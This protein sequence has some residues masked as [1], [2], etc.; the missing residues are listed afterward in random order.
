VHRVYVDN[1][2]SAT[3]SNPRPA[4]EE[5]MRDVEDGH[6]QIVV[7]WVL[8]RVLRTGRDRLRMLEL[9]KQRGITIS[10]VRGSDMDLSTP[11][12]R[13]AADMLGAVALHE[14]EAKSDRQKAAHRQAAAQGRRIG[15]RRPFGFEQDGMTVRPAEAKALEAAY[16]DYL[17]GTPLLAIARQ[18]NEAGLVS[19]WKRPDGTFSEWNHSGVRSV[20]RNARYAGFRVHNGEIA[21]KALWPA[22]VDEATYRAVVALLDSAASEFKP[23]GGR[24][25]LTG[26]ARCGVCDEPIHVGGN[27]AGSPPV[28]RCPTGK[29]VTRRAEPVED[30]VQRL[31]VAWLNTDAVRPLLAD[32]GDD[33][34]P[35]LDVEAEVIRGELL[36]I[37]RERT[38]RKI[39]REQFDV[40]NADL[41]A[42]LNEVQGRMAR[43]HRS[44]VLAE[45]ADRGVT[46]EEW[47]DIEI[48]Q[49]RAVVDAV[50]SI[51]LFSGGRGVRVPP[52]DTVKVTWKTPGVTHD[53]VMTQ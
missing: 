28:Y 38:Q 24:R 44:S 40:M 16:H 12:G 2:V 4:W 35:Q 42:Q 29:H 30:Q 1:D 46:M 48:G 3:K 11:S 41:Q 21:G 25:L 33:E 51:R 43:S 34:G 6:V 14:I 10:L 50:A 13:F 39:T 32:Q 53:S 17:A 9:G 27:K 37:A 20:L 18:W 36:T 22:L 47:L 31:I 52:P 49:R 8:D 19:G 7:G 45:L 26:I 15:G 5:M 23:K